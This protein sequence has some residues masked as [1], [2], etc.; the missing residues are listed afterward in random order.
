[1][2]T[3]TTGMIDSVV[4]ANSPAQ[5]VC[6]FGSEN[7]NGTPQN[8]G[9]IIGRYYKVMQH[10]TNLMGGKAFL[11]QSSREN[12]SCL[13]RFI[14]G[15]CKYVLGFTES[16]HYLPPDDYIVRFANFSDHEEDQMPLFMVDFASL[17]RDVHEEKLLDCL[18]LLSA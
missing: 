6:V 7:K 16:L 5:L 18:D 15:E 9:I 8:C 4:M 12:Y 17:G 1:M 10:L 11:D 14:R 3:T 13:E 2:N